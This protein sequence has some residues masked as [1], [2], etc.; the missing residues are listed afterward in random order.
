MFVPM[1]GAIAA[2]ICGNKSNRTS[3]SKEDVEEAASKAI[4]KE[5]ERQKTL[6]AQ[7]WVNKAK[8]E[9]I[10]EENK[11]FWEWFAQDDKE[12]E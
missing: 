3:L 7:A 9:R 1:T 2:L 8:K 4:K 5:I 11:A 10:A 6:E 12:E